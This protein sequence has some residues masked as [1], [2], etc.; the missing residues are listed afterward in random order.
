[1]RALPVIWIMLACAGCAA[2]PPLVPAD[3]TGAILPACQ[4]RIGNCDRSCD[5]GGIPGAVH[6]H[7]DCSVTCDLICGG[8]EGYGLGSP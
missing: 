8:R 3:A 5:K 7:A 4:D 1:M 6:V 2:S